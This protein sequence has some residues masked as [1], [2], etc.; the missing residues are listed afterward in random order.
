MK[1][2]PAKAGLFF[3]ALTS[4]PPLQRSGEE[5]ALAF[6]KTELPSPDRRR[7]IEDEGCYEVLLRGLFIH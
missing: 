7:R 5:G 6:I 2:S 1:K 3:T 4:R